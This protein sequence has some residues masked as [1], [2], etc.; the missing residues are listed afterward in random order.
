MHYGYLIKPHG[1]YGMRNNIKSLKKFWN[2][3]KVFLTGHTGFKG[4]WLSI[5]LKILGAKVTGY[6]LKPNQQTNYFDL[7]NIK[8]FMFFSVELN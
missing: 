5:F 7:A 8:N 1:N 2:N 4:A 3:K 6:T